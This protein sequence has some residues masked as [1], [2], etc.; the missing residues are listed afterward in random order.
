M[1]KNSK[2]GVGAASVLGAVLAAAALTGCTS[3]G[4]PTAGGGSTSAAASATATT[5]GG[6][7]GTAT[8]SATS[9]GTGTQPTASATD[10]GTSAC[11][12]A[13]L[14]V[15][16]VSAGVGAGHTGWI[17]V[18]T[19]TGSV[20]CSVEGYPGAGVTDTPG[21]VVLNATRS[22][23]GYL[24]GQYSSPAT[25]VLQ[26][27]GAASTVLEWVDFPPNGE[28][29]VGANCPGMDSG[30]VLITPPNT[31]QSTPFPAPA[32]LCADFMVHPLVP[33]TSG[34]GAQ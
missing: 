21:Q 33:G 4:S 6:T 31:R 24:G 19:N 10:E 34:R 23:S 8:A 29:P 28:T 22:Q 15:T 2:T 9:T 1:M 5:G 32:N 7:G 11:T 13:G 25:I 30:K 26:P 17:V 18:F 16:N 14:K 27:G 20:P 3:S 12:A